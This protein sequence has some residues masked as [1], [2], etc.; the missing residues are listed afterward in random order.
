MWHVLWAMADP[1]ATSLGR[2][3]HLLTPAGRLVL[4]EGRWSSG[5]GLTADHCRHLVLRHRIEADITRLEDP[6]LWG[7]P[8]ATSGTCSSAAAELPRNPAAGMYHDASADQMTWSM[9]ASREREDVVHTQ[10]IISETGTKWSRLIGHDLC[11]PPAARQAAGCIAGKSL[12]DQVAQ[13]PGMLKDDEQRISGTSHHGFGVLDV[14]AWVQL[15]IDV[16]G[17]SKQTGGIGDREVPPEPQG[18]SHSDGKRIVA[19]HTVIE[20]HGGRLP[21]PTVRQRS[22]HLWIMRS[23]ALCR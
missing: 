5:A 11:A 12:I 1:A 23:A 16:A 21:A 13:Q 18:H 2:R 7:A 17:R 19:D 6:A 4:V 20:R 9:V 8:S 10:A 22:S 15:A 14:G 3:V